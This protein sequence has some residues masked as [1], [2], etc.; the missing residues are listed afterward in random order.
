MK[1]TKYFRQLIT[2]NAAPELEKK[3]YLQIYTNCPEKWQLTDLETGD[4]YIGNMPVENQEN[5][6][7][8]KI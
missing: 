1:V 2:G 4:Q 3:I 7:W 5:L 8:R 6:S